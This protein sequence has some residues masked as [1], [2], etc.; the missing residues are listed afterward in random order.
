MTASRCEQILAAF[1][2]V[3]RGVTGMSARVYRD[4]GQ[5]LGSAELPSIA[6]DAASEDDDTGPSV[7]VCL[8]ISTLIVE[9]TI[10]VQQAPITTATDAIRSELH[11]RVMTSS[12][13]NALV[14]NVVPAGR[15]WVT[16]AQDFGGVICRYAVTY[17]TSRNDLTID[18]P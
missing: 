10:Y 3:A 5:A 2:T 13:I 15:Q 1:A 11:Q 16:E 17:Q 8:T 6:I 4:R 9:V 14:V 7:P 12:A 18:H